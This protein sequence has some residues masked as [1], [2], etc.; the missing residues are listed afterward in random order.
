M[1]MTAMGITAINFPM[2]PLINISGK[3][4]TTVVE[5]AMT[6]GPPTSFNPFITAVEGDFPR[7]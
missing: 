5:T 7:L 3:K 2:M 4:A 1:M 6:T